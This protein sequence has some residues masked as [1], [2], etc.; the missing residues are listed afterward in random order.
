MDRAAI[1]HLIEH[2]NPPETSQP[3]AERPTTVVVGMVAAEKSLSDLLEEYQSEGEEG[4]PVDDLLSY[5][6]DSAR[7]LDFLNS[8]RHDLGGGQLASIQHRDVKPENIL[9]VGDVAVICDFGVWYAN[10]SVLKR[11]CRII[12]VYSQFVADHGGQRLRDLG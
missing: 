1:D 11:L 7:G 2:A 5:M 3:G 12:N 9:L 4:I 6:E 8:P 10:L